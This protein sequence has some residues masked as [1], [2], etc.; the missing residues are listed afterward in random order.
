MQFPRGAMLRIL[1]LLAFVFAALSAP[2]Q[3]GNAGVIHGTVTDPSG[4]V[5]PNATIRLANPVSEFEQT[6]TTDA[7]GQFSFPNVPFNPYTISVTAKGFAAM[8]QNVEIRSAV[9][10]NVKLVLQ[11]S[12]GSQTVTV[13]SQGELI[14]DDP[15]FHVDVD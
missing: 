9:G 15:T 14:E 2:A 5:V 11:I 3:M 13:A 8:S 4:A 10:V 1:P 12:G 7:T 6:T